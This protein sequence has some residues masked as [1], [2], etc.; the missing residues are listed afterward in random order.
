MSALVKALLDDLDADDLAALAERLRPFLEPAE[1]APAADG[2][3]TTKRAAGHLGISVHAL[4]KLTATRAIVFEQSAP[5][6]KCWFR[7]RDLDAYRRGEGT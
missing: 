7:P 1:S 4:H 5:G 6:A 3:L 2:W